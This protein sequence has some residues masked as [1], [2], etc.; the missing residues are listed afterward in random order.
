M[1]SIKYGKYWRKG[2]P[3]LFKKD[4]RIFIYY[5]KYND[6]LRWEI[7][8]M[9]TNTKNFPNGK[10][11]DYPTILQRSKKLTHPDQVGIADPTVI[12]Y[13]NKYHMWFDMLATG[14]KW[15]LG[16]AISDDGISW[17]KQ[18]TKEKTDIILSKGKE[19]EWDDYFVHAPE[20]FIWKKQLRF[21]Y[22][23]KGK[24]DNRWH[25]GLAKLSNP[26]NLNSKWIKSGQ[27]TYSTSLL[28]GIS[29]RL[30]VPFYYKKNLYAVL[31]NVEGGCFV[32]MMTKDGG[33][34][35]EEVCRVPGNLWLV[36]FLEHNGKLWAI[37]RLN[38][39]LYYL[40]EK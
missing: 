32:F 9:I 6:K 37:N 2:Q 24:K 1:N 4:N 16:H 39:K 40:K 19:G 8:V 31:R 3:F 25:G 5:E 28:E 30:Q 15:T 13:N 14:W 23:A 38:Q 10:W 35:W 18:Q 12:Y 34:R 11:K 33:K 20:L 17:K 26:K 21:I 7:G 29:S 22:N 27:V 36:S